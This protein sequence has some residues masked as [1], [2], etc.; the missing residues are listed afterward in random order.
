MHPLISPPQTDRGSQDIGVKGIAFTLSRSQ[1]MN[2]NEISQ[3][4]QNEKEM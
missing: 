2:R 4:V 1:S 3:G